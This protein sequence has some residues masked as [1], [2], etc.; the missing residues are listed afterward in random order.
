MMFVV[1]YRPDEQSSLKPHHDASTYSIDVALNKRGIDYQGGGVRYVRYNCTVDADQIGRNKK[2]TIFPISGYSMI[3]P[4][5]LTHL[6][7]GLPTTEGTR[8]IAVSFLNP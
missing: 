8:Y 5:R 2:K 1:R 3:F 6:H 7:E 4:G